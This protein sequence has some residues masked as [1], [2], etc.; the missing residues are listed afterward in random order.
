MMIDRPEI[1]LGKTY[2]LKP[3]IIDESVYVTI[4]DAEI[5]GVMRPI[6]LF[7]N[8]KDMQS[9]QWISL[10]TRLLSAHMRTAEEF[11]YFISEEMM[12]TCDPHG[13]YY[14]PGTQSRAHSMVAPIGW[15]L[16]E[17]CR[18]LGL[19]PKEG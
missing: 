7:I 18:G 13:G 14:I 3:P 15:V 11:P 9:F 16:R 19:M 1:V 10:I 12:D 6:E 5:E 8:S 2:R 4:N 17:H